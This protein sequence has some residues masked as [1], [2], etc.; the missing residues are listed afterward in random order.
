[1]AATGELGRLHEACGAPVSLIVGA[2]PPV[3]EAAGEGSPADRVAQIA[4]VS[5]GYRWSQ[6]RGHLVLYPEA[7]EW[8][9]VVEVPHLAGPRLDVAD[10]LL[11]RARVQ[12]P[13]F[14]D[15]AGVM[16]RGDPASPVFAGEVTVEGR[17]PLIEHLAALLGDS[18]DIAFVIERSA[19]ARILRVERVGENA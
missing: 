6:P 15:L 3:T 7:P 17:A 4:A 16:Q 1:M 8:E 19:D 9:S 5:E 14:S 2:Q 13:E 10:D 12:I 18:S 11:A